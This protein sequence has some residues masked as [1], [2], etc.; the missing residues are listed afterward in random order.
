MGG[1]LVVAWVV[2]RPAAEFVVA[3]RG[4][5]GSATKGKVTDAFLAA[6]AEVCAEFDVTRCEIRGVAR[7]KRIALRFSGGFP[8]VARQR[9]RNW[10]AMSGWP[11][12]GDVRGRPRA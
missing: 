2:A 12:K 10:W 1:A 11:A 6:I 7:G 5:V 4:G 9:L 8:E 3:V